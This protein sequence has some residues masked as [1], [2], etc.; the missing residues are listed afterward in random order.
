MRIKS[1]RIPQPAA[2]SSNREVASSGQRHCK[3]LFA[4]A[5]PALILSANCAAADDPWQSVKE[6]PHN[7]GFVFVD[8]GMTC[9]FG[10]IEAVTAQSVLVRTDQSAVTFEKSS[11]TRI[12]YGYSGRPVSPSNP[13]LVLATVYSGRSSWADLIE[14]TPFRPTPGSYSSFAVRMSVKTTAGKVRQGRLQQ[15]T[16]SGITLADSFGKET[17]IA[18]TEVSRVDYITDK[19]LSD[20]QEFYWAEM[21]PLR[22]FDPALYPRLFHLGSTMSVRLYDRALPEDDSPVRCR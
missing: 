15:I 7:A 13:N 19:P 22:I 14:F 9:Q 10:H 17:S 18:R 20:N 4:L 3:A 12:R 6:L 2:V 21:G 11:L 5:L 16:D 1:L 8:R